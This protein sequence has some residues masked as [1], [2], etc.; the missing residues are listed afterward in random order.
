MAYVMSRMPSW[1]GKYPMSDT[2]H[3]DDLQMRADIYEHMH[4]LPRHDAEARAHADYRKE[5]I[6]K[7][8]AHHW[9]GM[10]AA[11]AAGNLE[12]AKKHGVMYT[13]AL[14][15]LGHKDPMN[16]PPEVVEAA[17]DPK[18]EIAHFKAHPGDMF[19]MP[20][21]EPDEQPTRTGNEKQVKDRAAL[22]KDEHPPGDPNFQ[23]QGYQNHPIGSTGGG[24]VHDQDKQDELIN[25]AY[26]GALPIENKFN[27]QNAKQPKNVFHEHQEVPAKTAVE[28]SDLTSSPEA[29]IL[30][31]AL[32]ARAGIR[33]LIRKH[34]SRNQ[35]N[36]TEDEP[37][38]GKCIACG[39]PY[40]PATGHLHQEN[41]PICG[42]CA[43]HFVAW[44]KS[45]TK[46]KWGGED[47]YE[48]AKTSIKPGDG[49][50]K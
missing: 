4:R 28:S 44:L 49:D 27:P 19:S 2:T 25:V 29:S 21:P 22:K 14:H 9:N 45:H 46:R 37:H 50:K 31:G 5:Q 6:A 47:F 7:A 3:S 38:D 43:K 34:A 10:K 17:K 36:K 16:P 35:M 15:Q 42:S 26:H 39:A 1:N 11:H 33:W 8:A 23:Q 41:A 48:A 24:L 18:S 32:A 13:L 20:P 12:S 40:H 30:A